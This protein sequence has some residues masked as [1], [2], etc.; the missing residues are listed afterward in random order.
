MEKDGRYSSRIYANEAQE[1]ISV[2][3]FPRM[4]HPCQASIKLIPAHANLLFAR[5]ISDWRA[6]I[7]AIHPAIRFIRPYANR[8][9]EW[10]RAPNP[11]K[12]LCRLENPSVTQTRRLTRRG[13]FVSIVET[14]PFLFF[15]FFF[16]K[17]LFPTRD[18]MEEERERG[19][20]KKKLHGGWRPL[21]RT[22]S[23]SGN[24][25]AGGASALCP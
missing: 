4:L 16:S 25:W 21:C 8:E 1:N 5:A 23:L 24:Q 15:S 2:I 14:K 9:R 13:A 22:I 3:S 17:E 10:S 6:P 12:H 19:E 11:I 7:I 18:S 20:E